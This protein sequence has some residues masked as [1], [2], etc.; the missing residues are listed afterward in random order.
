VFRGEGCLR[1]YNGMSF[2]FSLP[3]PTLRHLSEEKVPS[4]CLAS[5]MCL[6]LHELKSCGPVHWAPLQCNERS[7]SPKAFMVTSD[8]LM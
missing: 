3:A 2:N 5:A 1:F 8:V 7:L 6:S 4:F